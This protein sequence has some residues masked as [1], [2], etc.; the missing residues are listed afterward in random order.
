MRKEDG[1]KYRT[2]EE[3]A[4]VLRG[5]IKKPYERE[6]SYDRT[7][8]D[9]LSEQPTVEGPVSPPSEKEILEE[10]KSLRNKAPGDPDITP[11]MVKDII[12]DNELYT[13][14]KAIIIDFWEN[15]LLPE[16][17]ETGLL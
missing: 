9:L 11:R 4:E 15:E 2:S 5:H 13:V 12:T 17:G 14:L 1:T 3:N 8:L 16:Q 7:V 10:T 6:P